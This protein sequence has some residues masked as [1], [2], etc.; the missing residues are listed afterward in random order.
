MSIDV[1]RMPAVWLLLAML[2]LCAPHAWAE[3][4]LTLVYSGNLNGE[5]EPCGCTIEGDLGGI[6]R[7]ATMVDRLRREAPGLV[8]VSTGG[9][10]AS[11]A[12]EDRLTAEYILRG[13]QALDYDAIGVQ[14]RDLAYNTA[15]VAKRS[16]PWAA[17]NWRGGEFAKE[18]DI[19][20][21]PLQIAF[22]SWLDPAASPAHAGAAPL[23]EAAA[24]PLLRRLQKA[25]QRHALTLVTTPLDLATASHRLPLRDIDVLFLK[26]AYQTYGKPRRVGST[27]VLQP[28]SRGQRLGRVDLVLTDAPAIASYRQEVI[29][30][31][32]SVPD[33]PRMQAWY[34]AY[35]A[36]VKR[37]YQRTVAIRKQHAAG[38]SPYAGDQVCAGCHA[39]QYA[40]WQKSKHAGAYG[41]LEDV[42]KAFDPACIRCH[43]VGFNKPGGFIDSSATAGL[44]NVQC[45]NCHGA[46][47]RHVAAKGKVPVA[48]ATWRPQ[49]MCGQCHVPAHS[50]SFKFAAYWPRIR[51]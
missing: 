42:D 20:R 12:P 48:N 33:A 50:P 6:K 47:R 45:E 28:G 35:N 49:Q 37:A 16:L 22:F 18:R 10:I 30:L 32:P 38:T 23:V 36:A 41:A 1:R 11:E 44:E 43:T 3:T 26:S 9:L 2:S 15:F 25:K 31:P 39:A 46:A 27:L 51:H 13:L 5:L 7:R 40:V 17:S 21:G 19:Q 34:D 14:W 24:A 4:R 8:L 29:P